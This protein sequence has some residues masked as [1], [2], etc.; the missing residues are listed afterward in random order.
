MSGP[1]KCPSACTLLAA[2]VLLVAGG[3]GPVRSD[4]TPRQFDKP[5]DQA[6]PIPGPLGEL[7]GEERRAHCRAWGAVNA[8]G[9]GVRRQEDGVRTIGERADP[10]A[11]VNGQALSADQKSS[12]L[13]GAA[14]RPSVDLGADDQ[15]AAVAAGK[16]S[17]Q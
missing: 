13:D 12:V 16:G 5:T 9:H 10:L 3:V 8:T 7:Q 1:A 15:T 6:A 14:R 4:E 17:A 11:K 2:G